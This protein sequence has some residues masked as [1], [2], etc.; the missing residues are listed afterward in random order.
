M[1]LVTAS[2]ELQDTA[3]A[4]PPY[5]EIHPGSDL[6]LMEIRELIILFLMLIHYVLEHFFLHRFRV[7]VNDYEIIVEAKVPAFHYN[8]D[9]KTSRLRIDADHLL[10]LFSLNR[11]RKIVSCNPVKGRMKHL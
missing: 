5:K 8:D 10:I 9:V 6:L 11:R 2:S 3:A 4:A 7:V 1:K